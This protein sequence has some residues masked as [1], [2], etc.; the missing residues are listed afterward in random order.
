MLAVVEEE[1][2]AKGPDILQEAAVAEGTL[3]LAQY[4]RR[5]GVEAEVHGKKTLLVAGARAPGP[6]MKSDDQASVDGHRTVEIAI[7]NVIYSVSAGRSPHEVL[8]EGYG[9][10][11]GCPFDFDRTYDDDLR[12]TEPTRICD[13][14]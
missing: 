3:P 14:G 9:C 2:A 5:F 4:L 6:A 10:D 11:W 13:G 12:E 7:L 8:C 1:A